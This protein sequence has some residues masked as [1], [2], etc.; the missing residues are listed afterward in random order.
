M[1]SYVKGEVTYKTP[2]YILVEAGGI[3]YQVHISLN[4]YAQ[5]EKFNNF[6]IFKTKTKVSKWNIS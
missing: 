6:G 5:I 1:I 3:G 2:T 4:T